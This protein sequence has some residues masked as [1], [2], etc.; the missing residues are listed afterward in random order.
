[1]KSKNKLTNILIAVFLLL[2]TSCNDYLDLNPISSYNAGSFYQTENDFKLAVNGA[3][4]VLRSLHNG[5]II[6]TLECRSDNIQDDP[7]NSYDHNRVHRFENDESTPLLTSVWNNYWIMISRCNLILDKIDDASFDD[8]VA[9][10]YI[11]GEAYFLRGYAYFYLGFLYGGVPLIDGEMKVDEIKVMARSTQT[12]TFDFAAQDLAAA[13]SLLPEEWSAKDLGKATKYAAQ[14]IHARL[15]V[16]QKKFSE[17][18]P[19]LESIINSGNY[20]LADEYSHCF[21]D[22]YDNSKE[23]VFQVQYMS[24]N[25]GQ[26]NAWVAN[27]VHEFVVD[28]LFPWGGVSGANLVSPALYNAYEEG[29]LRKTFSLRKG[30]I[31]KQG[32]VDTVSIFYVKYAKGTQPSSRSDYELNMPVLRYTDVK[33]MYAEVLNEQNYVADGEAFSILNEIR[34]R[35][36]IEPLTASL[37]PTQDAF[38]EI[39]LHERRLE[40]AGEYLRWYDLVRSGKAMDV[41]NNHFTRTDEGGGGKF[42]M[43]E[44]HHIF[45]IPQRELDVNRDRDFMWQNPGY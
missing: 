30:Y 16:F 32:V 26:G 38:R 39:L 33:L 43:Q 44:H 29:D 20:Q 24:G 34:N 28:S 9:K 37:V 1:M 15:L 25:V 6:N 18:K 23:H 40:F 3:Y 27:A 14:G 21:L 36:D 13:A 2:G 42:S 11:K 10:G 8:E 12:E 19:L 5:S 31:T 17:A 22:S 35:A 4:A 41:M 7:I 45:P